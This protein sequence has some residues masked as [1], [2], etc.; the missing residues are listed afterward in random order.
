MYL[1]YIIHLVLKSPI[2]CHSKRVDNAGVLVE[3]QIQ[4]DELVSVHL[5]VMLWQS[6]YPVTSNPLQQSVRVLTAKSSLVWRKVYFLYYI[7]LHFYI[8]LLH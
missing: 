8:F 6:K 4:T 1:T 3:D 5:V 2:A 7:R